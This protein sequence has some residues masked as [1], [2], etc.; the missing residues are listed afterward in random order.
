[1][2]FETVIGGDGVYITSIAGSGNIALTY[3]DGEAS[4]AITS[5]SLEQLNDITVVVEWDRQSNYNGSLTVNGVPIVITSKT[6]GTYTGEATIPT[7]TGGK[8]VAK[9]AGGRAVTV[10]LGALVA[11][12]VSASFTGSY[13][14][15]QTELKAGDSYAVAII[16]DVPYTEVEVQDIGAGTGL[17]LTTSSGT[18]SVTIADRGNLAIERAATIRVKN[19]EG[20]WSAWTETSNTV[21]CSNVHPTFD[22]VDLQYPAGQ[23][24]I[25]G[26]EAFIIVN[27]IS[28]YDTVSHTTPS[29]IIAHHD[30][31]GRRYGGDYEVGD[32]VYTAV[33]NANGATTENTVGVQIA[34]VDV[35]LSATENP[36]LQFRSYMPPKE[37]S[38]VF[39]QE[40]LTPFANPILTMTTSNPHNDQ[41]RLYP[42]TV[43]NLSGM[44]VSLEREYKIKG[45]APKELEMVHDD[46]TVKIWTDIV[47]YSKLIITAYIN[48]E[49]PYAVA[50][51][52]VDTIEEVLQ[53]GQYAII[54]GDTLA[55]NLS[56]LESYGYEPNVNVKITIEET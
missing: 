4:G 6:G 24:A 29:A 27:E 55:F 32:C 47:D 34:H 56:A 26:N 54:D 44:E 50:I 8:I 52:R 1:M 10:E 51:S 39:T 46:A 5:A 37:L 19:A 16:S 13:P 14:A 22:S 7:V 33:R 36:I 12:V 41:V 9:M 23:R 53:V 21:L 45:F 20:T 43:T 25:K 11:P 40:L 31:G 49:P 38:C 30:N 48:T 2:G 42:L 35:A 3:E 18:V 15:G 28:N 17:S